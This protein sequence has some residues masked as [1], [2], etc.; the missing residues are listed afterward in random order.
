MLVSKSVKVVGYAE[1]EH[2]RI[3]V[4]LREP[5]PPLP[6]KVCTDINRWA[7]TIV[8]TEAKCPKVVRQISNRAASRIRTRGGKVKDTASDQNFRIGGEGAEV[9]HITR[10]NLIRSLRCA[11]CRVRVAYL[12]EIRFHSEMRLEIEGG[13]ETEASKPVVIGAQSLVA[14]TRQAKVCSNLEIACT[15]S[16]RNGLCVKQ[17]SQTS[18]SASD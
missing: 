4:L 7:N 1:A 3:E 11:S 16:G 18:D 8:G 5:R 15:R 10:A 9:P 6:F 12:T 14:G 2:L 13:V 17:W